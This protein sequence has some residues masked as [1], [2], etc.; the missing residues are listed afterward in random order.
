MR[1]IGI[2]GV[3]LVG[4]ACLLLA[5]GA[6]ARAKET[7]LPPPPLPD[8]AFYEAQVAGWMEENC[9][10]CHRRGAGGFRMARADGTLS[11]RL[12]RRAD[13]DALLPYVKRSAPWESRVYRKLLDRAEG[14][15]DHVGGS[16][17]G[18]EDE[19]HDTFLDFLSGATP[20]N[21]APEVWFESSEVRAKPGETVHLDGRGSFDRD[22]QDQDRLTYWWELY[23]RP[24]SSRVLVADRRASR[25]E[26]IPD[27]GGSYVFFL[28]VG[29]GTVWSAPRPITVEVFQHLA[30]AQKD[31]GGISGL[32]AV[33]LQGLQ[34][35]RRLY[36]D[37]LGRPPTPAEALAEEQSGP[38]AL[39]QNI[40]LRAESGRAWVE[41]LRVRFG[42]LG[43]FRPVGEEASALA[44]R[45]PAENLPPP[46]VEAVLARDPS[47]L[48]RH[49]TGR[50]LATAIATLLLDR[51]PT[52]AELD[53]AARLAAGEAADVPGI[54]SVRDGRAWLLAVLES[55]A[56]QRAAV[57]R[58]LQRFLDSGDV[59]GQTG[60]ALLAIRE[61][62]RKWR[63]L[64]EELLVE[65]GYLERKRLR[66]KGDVT[67]L[68]G[69]FIDLLE[70]GPTDR[71]LS[72]LVRALETMPGEG[73][74]RAALARLLID[75]GGAPIPLLVEIR[76]LPRWITDRFLRYIGRKPTAAELKAYGE[77]AYL[78]G[79]GPKLVIQ[80]LLTGAEYACR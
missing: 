70:R 56:F 60:R 38:R 76:D 1:R 31:P 39:V 20:T 15:D 5:L 54:G 67:F 24:A 10:R 41:E 77:A 12:R 17:F 75:T 6:H 7:F 13:F 66:P 65:P 55:D 21:L 2:G 61:S 42:L 51:E 44:L 9:A 36:L 48:A 53:A 52:A 72:A 29:D 59:E 50:A 18:M 68:R 64:L 8:F 34:R 63:A 22:R 47:F 73:A 37:V 79:G 19:V 3:R 40:L 45:V 69:L 35:V 71:E 25:L 80:A 57:R 58:R 28:R 49:P 30:V 11:E 16:F 62:N 27:T 33:D 23:A 46:V 26:F 43:D 74:A 32:D 14:G 4:A 78:D